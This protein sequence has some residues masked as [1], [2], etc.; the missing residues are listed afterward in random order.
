MRDRCYDCYDIL[1]F[2]ILHERDDSRAPRWW[3]RFASGF[4]AQ[5]DAT[6]VVMPCFRSLRPKIEQ[7]M[8]YETDD[9]SDDDE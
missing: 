3:R 5:E 8:H 2:L 9:E 1:L 4:V 6:E 7:Q